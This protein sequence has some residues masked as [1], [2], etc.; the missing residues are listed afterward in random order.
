M[1]TIASNCTCVHPYVLYNCNN[2]G[3]L[4][5]RTGLGRA[6]LVLY[7]VLIRRACS[8]HIY[9]ENCV[10]EVRVLFRFTTPSIYIFSTHSPFLLVSDTTVFGR[11]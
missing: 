2:I 3:L 5:G 8:F 7:E 10:T 9:P 4:E 11:Y 6:G 1:N